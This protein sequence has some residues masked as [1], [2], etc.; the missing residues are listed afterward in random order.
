MIGLFGIF[1]IFARVR[2]YFSASAGS[3][4]P[5]C[6]YVISLF[7]FWS[8]FI[9]FNLSSGRIT[10]I[11]FTKKLNKGNLKRQLPFL[12]RMVGKGKLE[13]Q[14][15]TGRVEGKRGRGI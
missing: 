4:V 8:L 15:L 13:N 6:M 10:L 5:H 3:L 1:V 2:V 7:L 9:K 14:I 11:A 12:G